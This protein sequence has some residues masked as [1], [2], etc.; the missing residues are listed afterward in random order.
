M[1]AQHVDAIDTPTLVDI[2][3]AEED[4]CLLGIDE[5][6]RGIGEFFRTAG[7]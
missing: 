2:F 7:G 6:V 1:A 4:A 5:A 3:P